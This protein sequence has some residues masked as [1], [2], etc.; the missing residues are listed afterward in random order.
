MIVSCEMLDPVSVGAVIPIDVAAPFSA[1]VRVGEATTGAVVSICSP[2]IVAAAPVRT[3]AL[4]APSVMLAPVGRMTPVTARAAA[5]CP[6]ATVALN[7]RL[8][9]PEP[10]T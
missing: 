10:L 8:L 2:V 1:T 9:P 5:F 7:T 4:P 6:A 3:A